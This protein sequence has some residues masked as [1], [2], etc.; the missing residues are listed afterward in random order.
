MKSFE[1]EYD[2]LVGWIRIKNNEYLEAIKK[3]TTPG[4]DGK[5]V[6]ERA[7]VVNEYNR[8]LAALKK[9]YGIAAQTDTSYEHNPAHEAPRYAGGK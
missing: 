3:D 7:K 1:Q 2:K 8:R 5:L 9:K 4:R 6:Y